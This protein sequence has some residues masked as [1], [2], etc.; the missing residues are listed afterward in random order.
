MVY[1]TL[2]KSYPLS[3]SYFTFFLFLPPWQD[4]KCELMGLGW[5]LPSGRKITAKTIFNV[6]DACISWRGLHACR[7]LEQAWRENDDYDDRKYKNYKTILK[8]P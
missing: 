2:T 6:P 8:D 5:G 4:K 7:R 3:L 1:R